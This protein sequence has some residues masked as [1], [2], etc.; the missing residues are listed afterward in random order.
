MH[1]SEG[2]LNMPVLV[3]GFAC[4]AAGV[5]I[6]VKKMD[7]DNIPKIAVLSAAFF[8]ASLIHVPMGFVSVHLVL[9]GLVGILLGWTAFPAIMVALA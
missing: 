9:N 5:A 3:T 6:G 8:V 1:I 4:A 2:V 7:A